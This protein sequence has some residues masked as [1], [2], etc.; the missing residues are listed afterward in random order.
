M[1]NVLDIFYFNFLTDLYES[2]EE[3]KAH[4]SVQSNNTPDSGQIED[5]Q[6]KE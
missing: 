5:I 3:G 6:G 4:E 2:K 1:S